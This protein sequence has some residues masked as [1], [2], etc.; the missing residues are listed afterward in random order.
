[1]RAA[2]ASS[3]PADFTVLD[4]IGAAVASL[5]ALGL[6]ALPLVGRAFAAMYRDLGGG[7]IPALTRLA[8]SGWLPLVLGAVVAGGIGVGVFVVPSLGV[9]RAVIVGAF[10]F[11]LAAIAFCL[12]ALYL[13]IFQLAGNVK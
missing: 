3:P 2:A 5:T 1:M 10:L 13:P 4:W 11:G 6:F 7:S 8:L 12:V 9:R